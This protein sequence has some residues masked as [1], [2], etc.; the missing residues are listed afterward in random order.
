MFQLYKTRNFNAIVNDSF[1]FFKAT[2]KNYF[3]NYFII[4]GPLLL[5]L[6]VLGFIFFKVFYQNIFSGAMYADSPEV[7]EGYFSENFGMML[8]LGILTGVLGLI[9]MVINYSYPV[10]YLMLMEKTDKPDTKLIIST[11]KNRLWKAIVFGLLSLVT[12]LPLFA[13]VCVVAFFL[14]IIIIGFPVSVILVA[15]FLCWMY[16]SFYN[17]LSTDDGFFASMEVGYNM[18]TRNFWPTTG[19]TAIFMIILYVVQLAMMVVGMIINM[20]YGLASAGPDLENANPEAIMQTMSITMIVGFVIQTTVSFVMG[21]FIFINQGIIYYSGRDRDD[22]KSIYNDID[23]IG[24]D[25]E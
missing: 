24:R 9:A 23:L 7:I 12:F 6:L 16:Q 3:K 20:L 14:A 10:I 11:L 15:A 25:V 8:G 17:Y 18:V 22:N 19:S 2:G 5:I 21:N 13:L 1:G 4:N